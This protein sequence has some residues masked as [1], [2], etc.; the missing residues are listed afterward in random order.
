MKIKW[1][2]VILLIAMIGSIFLF[3]QIVKSVNTDIVINEIGAFE[4]VGYEWLEIWNKGNEAISLDGWK[5][6][7]DGVNH[8]LVVSTT[9]NILAPGEYG[10]ICQEE[11]KFLERYPAFPGS[12]FDSSWGSLNESGEEIGLKDSENNWAEVLFIYPVA[13]NYSLERISAN[14]LA[15]STANWQEHPTGN[16]LGQIN[17]WTSYLPPEPTATTTPTSTP[18]AGKDEED[19]DNAASTTYSAIYINEFLPDPSTSSEHEWIEL[20]NPTT[21]TVDLTGW[22]LSDSITIRNSPTGTIVAES[23]FVVELS[24]ILNNTGDAIILKNPVNEISDSIIYGTGSLPV[25]AKGNSL[26]RSIDGA[27]DWQETTTRTKNLEN[28]ITAPIVEVQQSNTGGGSGSPAPQ[29]NL[30]SNNLNSAGQIIINELLPNPQGADTENEFIELKNTVTEQINLQDWV[31]ADASG[32]YKI[33]EGMISSGGF[34]VFKRSLTNLALNNSGS[35]EVKLFNP[36]GN[37]IDSVKYLGPVGEAESYA[38]KSDS[39]WA[40]TIKLTP[41]TENIFVEKNLAPVVAVEYLKNAEVG[42]TA[43]FDASDTYDPE[44]DSLQFTWSTGS[45]E[46]NG[47]VVNFVFDRAGERVVELSVADSWG[48][49]VEKKFKI[50]VVR[51]EAS[52]EIET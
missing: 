51:T 35:E 40:W 1:S 46:K 15:S 42:E 38:R 6:V 18:E 39:A 26:A 17:Y 29:D 50:T 13:P 21:S 24:N 37:L 11:S 14:E 8:G 25:P 30:P 7:E 31:I 28:I 19:K 4:G 44:G 43:V 10:A 12:I 33:K 22:T 2:F 20:Y 27:G 36:A 34:M 41:G 49:K 23:F 32:K 47:P 45:E 3:T 5:F 48:N 9:D 16:T 52:D